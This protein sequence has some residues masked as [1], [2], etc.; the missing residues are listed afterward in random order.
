MLQKSCRGFRAPCG[1]K[2]FGNWYSNPHATRNKA[3]N[4]PDNHARFQIEWGPVT[5]RPSGSAT[6]E[7]DGANGV[8]VLLLVEG[9][10]EAVHTGI[11]VEEERNGVAGDGVPVGVDEDWERGELGEKSEH[12]GFHG[13]SK[14]ELGTLFEE[15][16]GG[17]FP[18]P[19]TSQEI[20]VLGKSTQT[21][22]YLLRSSGLG[23]S[24]SASTF[25]EVGMRSVGEVV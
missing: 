7:R 24:I 22:A 11:E 10:I 8:A 5:F 14:G 25:C 21:G 9:G 17:P 19:H 13:S 15:R 3:C 4:D 6:D 18:L 20:P 12:N 1:P 2:I 16:G 23:I